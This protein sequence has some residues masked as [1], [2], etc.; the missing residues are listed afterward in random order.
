M[1]KEMRNMISKV[2]LINESYNTGLSTMEKLIKTAE[3]DG[4]LQGMEISAP[5]VT[6]AAKEI[7]AKYD[8]LSA[9]EQKVYRN[10]LYQT[11]LKKI[12]KINDIDLNF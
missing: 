9:E 2:N 5:Y 6:S 10:T 8:A 1:S 7:A 12:G 3:R 11:F 4:Y